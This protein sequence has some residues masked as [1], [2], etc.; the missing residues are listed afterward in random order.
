MIPEHWTPHYRDDDGELIGYLIPAA[1][2]GAPVDH[3]GQDDQVVPATVFGHPLGEP[4]PAFAAETI[5]NDIGLS[6]LAD[7]WRLS[8][9]DGPVE[10]VIAEASPDVVVV[11]SADYHHVLGAPLGTRYTLRVPD[12]IDRLTRA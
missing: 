10:V 3:D 2:D 12:E 5:L 7:R 8:T 1:A 4:M 11:V 9:S 6:Y